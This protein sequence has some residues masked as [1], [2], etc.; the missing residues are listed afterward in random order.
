MSKLVDRYGS[1]TPLGG[2]LA[3]TAFMGTFIGGGIAL[4]KLIAGRRKGE[5]STGE[6]DTD[7]TT[8]DEAEAEAEAEAE[9]TTDDEAD[10]DEAETEAESTTTSRP[11]IDLSRKPSQG[12]KLVPRK[13]PTAKPVPPKPLV[14]ASN[15]K[16]YNGP[17]K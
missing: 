10:A 5:A 6:A 9:S 12:F 1:L 3:A 14:L 13:K 7:E 16:I 17:T 11:L 4:V 15:A 2:V 8:D